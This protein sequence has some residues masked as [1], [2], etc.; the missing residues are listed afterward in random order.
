MSKKLIS[1]LGI[2]FLFVCVA[3]AFGQTEDEIVARY[4]QKAEKKRQDKIGFFSANF[5]YGKLPHDNDYNKFISYANSRISPGSPLSGIWRTS[6]IRAECGMMVSPRMAMRLGFDYWWNLGSEN[7]GDY[8]LSIA[9]LGVQNDFNLESRVQ[10]L[11]IKGGLDYYILNPPNKDGFIEA[12]ALRVGLTGGVYFAKWEIWEGMTSFNL[13]TA[14]F[15]QNIDPLK[16][17]APGVTAMVGVEYPTPVFDLLLGV[18]GGYQYLNF[19]GVKSYNTLD[20]ELYVSYSDTG[21]DRV[22]L[23]LSGLRGRIELKRFFRW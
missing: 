16:A 1:L 10:V 2:I 5:T 17:T 13:S 4:L 22:E 6:Q 12:L 3:S 14:S 7:A 15:E 9:P 23:D 19:T 21:T 20:E 18:S 11:G 8:T